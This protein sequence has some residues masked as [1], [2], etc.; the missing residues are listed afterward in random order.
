VLERGER[1]LRRAVV[2]R[3]EEERRGRNGRV[4]RLRAEDRDQR[5]L[6]PGVLERAGDGVLADRQLRSRTHCSIV[7]TSAALLLPPPQPA[8]AATSASA[9]AAFERG[10]AEL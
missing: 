10:T 9:A 5:V 3:E 8:S 2:L 6:D 4:R 7:G 1:V